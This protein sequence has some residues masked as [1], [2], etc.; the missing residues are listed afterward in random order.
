MET[1]DEWMARILATNGSPVI[2]GTYED[3]IIKD[4]VEQIQYPAS[5]SLSAHADG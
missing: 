1:F 5:G 4:W 2:P 3:S